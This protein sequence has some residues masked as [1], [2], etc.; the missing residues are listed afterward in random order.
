MLLA[1][2]WAVPASA[3][4]RKPTVILVHGAFAESASWTP[5]IVELEKAGYPVIAA[6]NPLRGLANDAAYVA[7]IVKATPG[8][9]V[10]VG[11]SY[12]GAVISGAAKDQPNVKALVIVA[13]FALEVGESA[14][15]I[16]SKFPTGTLG[17]ALAD[18][19]VQADGSKDLY[20]SNS[21][22][23]LQFAAD[24]PAVEAAIMAAT[25]RPITEA[26]FTEPARAAAWKT[27]P[28]RFIY[29]LE[30]K[31]IPKEALAFMAERAR[32]RETVEVP[33]AS[34]VVMISHPHA[35]AAMIDRAA[36]AE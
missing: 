35:V 8:K 18:P 4:P 22:F 9:V 7:S 17:Q 15:A 10:L 27:I 5:V 6:A 12:G 34:H 14:A 16:G 28:T 25:Q 31:N 36:R 30:D 21:K 26:A 13:G 1:A 24:V 23:R 29:G 2:N 32:S 33:G 3:Q 11:H 19:V 20:I